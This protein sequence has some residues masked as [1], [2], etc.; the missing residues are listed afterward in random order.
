ML[1]IPGAEEA[2]AAAAAANEEPTNTEDLNTEA[3]GEEQEPEPTPDPNEA[4]NSALAAEKEQ[5]IRLEERLA[6]QEAAPAPAQVEPPKE[7][8]R[9]QLREA[10]DN[11]QLDQD[12]METMWADQ[13]EA[14]TLRK[15]EEQNDARDRKR[16]TANVI[17]TDTA[18]YLNSHPDIRKQGSSDWNRLKGEYDYLVS[19]GDP[20]DKTTELKAMRAAFGAADRIAESSASRRQTASETSGAQGGAGPGERPVDIWNR[21][22]K[23]LRAPLKQMVSSGTRTL[24]DIK[25]DLPYMKERP[26]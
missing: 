8:T 6:A 14:R 17:Q 22:P 19:L 1:N 12:Q 18:K 11:G 13:R 23:H 15:V 21:V 10:V 3:V 25:K 24:E 5:R 7:L 9:A 26:I 16:D 2:Q 4:L 20:D